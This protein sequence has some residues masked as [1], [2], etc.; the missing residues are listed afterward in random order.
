[1]LCFFLLNIAYIIIP[2]LQTAS[3]TLLYRTSK[4]ICLQSVTRGDENVVEDVLLAALGTFE[5]EAATTPPTRP[6]TLARLA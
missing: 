3:Y 5:N 6:M 2:C 1:M 4:W